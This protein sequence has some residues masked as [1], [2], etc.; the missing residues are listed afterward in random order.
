MNH[1]ENTIFKKIINHNFLQ[2]PLN[3]VPKHPPKTPTHKRDPK[4]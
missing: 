3:E 4:Y 2:E 1:E